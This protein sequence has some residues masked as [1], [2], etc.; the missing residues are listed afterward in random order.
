MASSDKLKPSNRSTGEGH[1]S[2]ICLCD[3]GPAHSATG[4]FLP[5]EA[6]PWEAAQCAAAQLIPAAAAAAETL[7][8][9]ETIRSQ[10]I[11]TRR[12]IH[13]EFL[14]KVFAAFVQDPGDLGIERIDVLTLPVISFD[15]AMT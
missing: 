10:E 8:R 5:W 2:E 15:K 3:P 1:S 14:P 9:K 13:P 6:V 11:Y 7:M 12:M 4:A